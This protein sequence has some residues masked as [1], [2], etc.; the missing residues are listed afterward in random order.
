MTL[1]ENLKFTVLCDELQ[2]F[3]ARRIWTSLSRSESVSVDVVDIDKMKIIKSDIENLK[4]GYEDSDFDVE[5]WSSHYD[6]SDIRFI[7]RMK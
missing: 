1:V 2:Y 3:G 7:L 5:Y 6:K 4:Q